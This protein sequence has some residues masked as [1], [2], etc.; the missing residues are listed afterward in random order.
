MV[1]SLRGRNNLLDSVQIGFLL[2]DPHSR[3]LY[4][5]RQAEALFGYRRRGLEGQ[6]IRVLFL[7]EDLTYL[8]PNI[9]YLTLYQNGFTGEALLKQKDGIKVFVEISTTS[10]KEEGEVFL[11]FSFQEIQRLKTL[12]KQKMEMMR[13]A[14]LGMLMEEIAH[15]IRNPI[16]SIGGY[17]QRLLK[18]VSLSRKGKSYF[19]YILQEA[20][21]LESMVKRME[22]YVLIPKP[23]FQKVRIQEV[24]EEAIWAFSKK[25]TK[26]ISIDLEEG[27]LEKSGTLFMDK[28]LIMKVISHVLENGMETVQWVQ[29]KKSRANLKITIFDDGERV[30]VSIS[31]RGEGIPKRNLDHIFNPF[32]STWPGH[33]GLGL[34]FVKRI[35]DEHGGTI[36]VESRFRQG[37]TVSLYF[38]KDRRR[39]IRRELLSQEAQKG[40]EI[41]SRTST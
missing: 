39:R 15:Q 22:E 4:A 13:W 35:M 18:T 17:A 20:K 1:N 9:V 40:R 26:N 19:Q 8:L 2:T 23:V 31:D 25:K 11:A 14:S 36:R 27:T 16:A 28:N 10:F 38:I 21:R 12:E 30:G 6:R 41:P 37:T 33:T 34:T 32:F 7:H 5:N 3:I 29:G 24:V